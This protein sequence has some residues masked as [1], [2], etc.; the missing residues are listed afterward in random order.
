[1][2]FHSLLKTCQLGAV[3]HTSDRNFV[4]FKKENFLSMML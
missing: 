2:L 1:M 4:S 3:L